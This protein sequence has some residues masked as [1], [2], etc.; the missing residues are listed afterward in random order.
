MWDFLGTIFAR[1]SPPTFHR[2]VS[3]GK[4]RQKKGTAL[5]P[6]IKEGTVW[7]AVEG[8]KDPLMYLEQKRLAS[9]GALSVDIFDQRMVLQ[10]R[11]SCTQKSLARETDQHI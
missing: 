11:L 2:V 6:T 8:C 9:E 3:L 10:A 5:Q 1:A 7:I 4:A